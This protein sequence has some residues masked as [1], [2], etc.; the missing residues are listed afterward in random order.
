MLFFAESIPGF[1]RSREV[2]STSALLNFL[3]TFFLVV[4]NS[5]NYGKYFNVKIILIEESPT[6]GEG[7]KFPSEHVK[8]NPTDPAFILLAIRRTLR[9]PFPA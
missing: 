3:A 5:C 2:I 6:P 7:V 8:F 1:V 9:D 4:P